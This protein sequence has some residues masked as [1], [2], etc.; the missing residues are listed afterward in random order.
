MPARKGK[1]TKRGG[2][3]K[4]KGRTSSLYMLPGWIHWLGTALLILLIAFGAYTFLLK[5]YF[6]RWLPCQGHKEYDVCVPTGFKYY[7]IDVSHHQGRIDWS[8]VASSNA[9]SDCPVKFVIIKATEGGTFVDP[10]FE[11]NLKGAREAGFVCGVYHFFNPATPAGKQAEFYINNVKLN[12][13][14]FAPVVDVERTGRSDKELQD[15]LSEFLSI[16]EK[17]YGVKP[18]IYA[19]AKFRKRHLDSDR[20]NYYPVWIAHYYVVRPD[21]DVKW[22]IWQFTDRARV[23]GIAEY[24]DLNVFSGTEADFNSLRIK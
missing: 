24:T 18:I 13:G 11:T 12:K 4:K 9:E 17:H 6:Y 8:Q 10:D 23:N 16:I 3:P 1:K 5:P 21:S 15:G 7:G 14:D 19:S 22:R 2:T 20:F